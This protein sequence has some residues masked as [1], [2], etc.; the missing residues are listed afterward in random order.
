MSCL[1][2]INLIA[3][4]FFSKNIEKKNSQ[5]DFDRFQIYNMR[6]KVSDKGQKM[7]NTSENLQVHGSDKGTF[8]K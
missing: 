7:I 4:F 8:K 1:L 5:V 6:L 3:F 2:W